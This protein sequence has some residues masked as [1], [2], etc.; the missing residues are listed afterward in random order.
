MHDVHLG[1]VSIKK[2]RQTL[3]QEA[4]LTKGVHAHT[5]EELESEIREDI[6]G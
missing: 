2:T 4:L 1:V 6:T 3:E 5:V